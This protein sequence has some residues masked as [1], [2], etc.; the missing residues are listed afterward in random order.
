MEILTLLKANI[1]HKKGSFLS[2]I[3]LMIIISMSFTAIISVKD[4]CKTS[5]ENALES[6]DAGDLTVYFANSKLTDDLLNSVENH[7]DVKKVVVTPAVCSNKSEFGKNTISEAWFLRVLTDKY[8]VLNKDLTAYAGKTPKLQKGEIY[9]PQGAAT[10]LGCSVGDKIKITT[11]GGEYEFIVKAFVVEPVNGCSNMGWKQ[12]FVSDEDFEKLQADTLANESDGNTSDFRIMQIYKTDDCGLS[13][14]D[15]KRQLNLDTGVVD[16]SE[17]SMQKEQ[18]LYYTNIFPDIILSVL[19]VFICFL[20]VI[21][22][23]VMGHSIS[24]GIEMDYTNLGV[25][26]SQG[27]TKEKI[28]A[29]FVLQY[30]IAEMIGAVIGIML[31]LPLIF[32]LGNIFQPVTAILAENNISVVK[33][34]IFIAGVLLVSAVFIFFITRKVGRISPVR[35][36]SGGKREIYF[37]SRIKAP[38]S[39]KLLSSS[40][41]LRQFTANKRRYLGTF[42]IVS[43]LI[44]FMITMNILTNSIDSKSAI[45][46]MGAIYTECDI[47]FNQEPDDTTIENID[48]TIEKYSDI[49]KKYYLQGCYRSINGE[50]YHCMIYKN[51]EVI[52]ATKGRA[53]LYD[54]EIIVTEILADELNIKIGDKV[55]VSHNNEKAQYLVS[56]FYSSQNDVGLCFAMSSEGAEKLGNVNILFGGYSLSDPS[57]KD[58]IVKAVNKD[59]SDIAKAEAISDVNVMGDVSTLAIN[60]M[61]AIIYIFSV[62]FALVVVMMVCTKTFLQE[63]RDIGIYKSLG[64]TAKKLRLQFAVRFLIISIIGSIIGSLLSLALSGTVI[65][66]V[67]RQIGITSFITEFTASI[68][69]LPVALICICFFVFAYLASRKIKRVEIKELITE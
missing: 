31:S 52:S 15:F 20:V 54:N 22:L 44:F 33:S 13:D 4:N 48:K 29:V 69:V 16:N 58:E 45:E 17:G 67:L 12:I 8:K 9:I 53:P 19:I 62:I 37:E 41:A 38:I 7:S 32:F 28:R 65:S 61:K 2:I 42:I 11:F 10:N 66:F 34:L 47:R 40:L 64:F 18:S 57:K 51:P 46:S 60:A 21:V 30:L 49:E 55:T 24:T 43:I 23:I 63:R 39:Q 27:F 6:V 68:F 36:I 26:K 3:I 5:I 59:F 14:K 50:E 35:A 1:R 56:G 25:L